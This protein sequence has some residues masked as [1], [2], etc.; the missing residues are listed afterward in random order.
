MNKKLNIDNLEA[1]SFFNGLVFFAPVALLVRTRA[2]VSLDRFFILQAILSVTIFLGEIP[3]GKITDV[4]GY[5][6]AIV[7]SQVMLLIARSMLLAAFLL[8][9]YYIFITEAIIEG[10]ANCFT[11]GTVSA[12]LYQKYD[13]GEYPVKSA[14]VGNYGTAG[15]ITS[16]IMYAGIYHF[17]EVEG[18]LIL[19]VVMNVIAVVVSIGI[20][21]ETEQID[22]ELSVAS[23]ESCS[24]L[25][26]FF[27]LKI[28]AEN[29]II[30]ITLACISISFILINFFY[31][32]KLDILGI[33]EEWMTAI[34][35]GYSVFQMAAEKVLDTIGERNYFK[36]FVIGFIISGMCMLLFG[37][38]NITPVIIPI[39]LILPLIVSVPAYIFD[40]MENKVID[41]SHLEDKRAEALSAYNMGVNLVEVLFLFVSAFVAELGISAC[42]T[43]LGILMILLA[44]VHSRRIIQI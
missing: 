38:I 25:S 30:M 35:L 28:N 16:T 7:L 40:E 11:S 20:E 1:V 23:K 42:F 26:K 24:I 29:I 21:K 34:I 41:N 32:D 14:R 4:V 10:I 39:M 2:G 37:R 43:V 15:F 36:A 9:N 19:T 17:Y 31:V 18:L 5:K 6:N 44:G 33:S 3:T 22:T 13:E 12:Y 27:I 8:K